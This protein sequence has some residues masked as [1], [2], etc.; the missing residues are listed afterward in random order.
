MKVAILMATKAPPRLWP[1]AGRDPS[2]ILAAKNN[3]RPLKRPSPFSMKAGVSR[4]YHSASS[5]SRLMQ[6]AE[7]KTAPIALSLNASF[8]HGAICEIGA[9]PIVLATVPS[10]QAAPLKLRS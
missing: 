10:R 8:M 5:Q 1:R 2:S 6:V 4:R 9:V 3:M 7:L